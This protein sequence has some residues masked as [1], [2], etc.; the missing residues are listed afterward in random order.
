MRTRIN[1]NHT[2]ERILPVTTQQNLLLNVMHDV[3]MCLDAKELYRYA[4][5][6][7]AS[8]S[9]SWRGMPEN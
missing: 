7:V 9:L 2:G 5:E 4:S 8:T 6:K 1:Y 3:G